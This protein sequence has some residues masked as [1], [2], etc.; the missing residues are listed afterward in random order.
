MNLSEKNLSKYGMPIIIA[1]PE[2]IQIQKSE[3]A[4]E[5]GLLLNSDEYNIAID[6]YTDL[7]E[8]ETD[9][10]LIL[11]EEKAEISKTQGFQNIIKEHKNGFLY[12]FLN[13]DNLTEY[14]FYVVKFHK[15]KEYE[16]TDAIGVQRSK[17]NMEQIFDA[18]CN[19]RFI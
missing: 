6:E 8:E 19:L 14:H 17:S 2:N 9:L 16:I 4:L 15:Q 12:E 1:A 18:V 11:S 3:I 13:T 7:A 5:K 10:N